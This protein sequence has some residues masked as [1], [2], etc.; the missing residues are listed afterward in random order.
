MN[1]KNEI[2]TSLFS[3]RRPKDAG[4]GLSSATKSISKSV[5]AGAVSL[6]AQPIA[7]AQQEGPKGFFKGLATGVASAVALPVVGVSVGAYQIVRGIANQGEANKAFK[8]G[9]QWDEQKRE[10]YFY[11]LDKEKEQVENLEARLK[12]GKTASGGVAG[13]NLSERK[14]KDRE[15][16]DLLGVSTNATAAEIKKAYYKEARMVHPD[17]CPDDPDAATKFQALGQAYQILSDEQK[18]ASYDKNGK[19]ENENAEDM[20]NAIDTS[21]FFNVMFGSTLVE[22]YV[23]ELWISSIADLMM[24]DLQQQSTM[25]ESEMAEHLRG[26]SDKTSEEANL[27]QKKREIKIALYLRDKVKDVVDGK[28]A[29]D[30]FGATVQIEACKIAEGS[31]GSTFLKNI[32][33]ALEIEAEEYIGFQKSHWDGAR[34]QTKKNLSSTATNFK[35]TGAAIKA[36]SAG[37][38]A[39]REVEA[40]TQHSKGGEIDGKSETEKQAEQ[41]MLAAKKFEESLPSILELAWGINTRDIRNTLNEACK[42]LFAD[43]DASLEQRLMRAKAVKV[44]GTEFLTIGKMVG[45]TKGKEHMDLETIKSR[46][47]VAVMTTMAKAQG[48]EVNENDTEDLIRQHK[49]MSAQRDAQTANAQFPV[50]EEQK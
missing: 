12:E 25:S 16:Y 8:Q 19:S 26:K 34:V 31:F 14:V 6:V 44:I 13:G 38:K 23:G 37:H 9:M 42:K 45:S 40:A 20:A 47:E 39:Y 48:Q 17:K 24:K 32:G 30:D 15:Y 11:Y 50:K 2:F 28:V 41:A 46:A 4:A 1:E 43:A 29:L 35:I 21:V 22:P 36:A 10:W 49:E 27:K 3:T 18:R 7:G 33:F 5:L